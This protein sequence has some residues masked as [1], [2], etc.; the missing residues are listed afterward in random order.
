M[1]QEKIDFVISAYC[2]IEKDNKVLLS[3]DIGKDGWKISGGCTEKDELIYDTVLREVKEETGFDVKLENLLC[4]QEYLKENGVHRLRVYTAGK[5]VSGTEKLMPGEIEKIQWFT[6]KELQQLQ[7]SD[8]FIKQYY[9]AVQA[10]LSNKR[11]PL[12]IISLLH[13]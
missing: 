4:V 8:F 9:D 2:F 12:D 1:N 10:Y 13:K 6:Q 3:R 5:Y 11:Y 7:P